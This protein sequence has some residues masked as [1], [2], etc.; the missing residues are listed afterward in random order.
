MNN[1]NLNTIK[2]FKR[3]KNDMVE[4]QKAIHQM[5][6]NQKWLIKKVM[7]L[8]NQKPTEKRLVA[9]KESNKVHAENC[10]FAKNINRERMQF[11]ETLEQATSYGY[12]PCNCTA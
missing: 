4:L 12:V 10:P 3:V 6:D 2:S 1:F 8:Q 5:N 11:F 7:E 9:S